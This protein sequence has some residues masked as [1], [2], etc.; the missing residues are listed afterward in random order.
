M[1]PRSPGILAATRALEDG[2]AHNDRGRVLIDLLAL[3]LLVAFALLGAR[4]GALASATLLVA[5]AGGYLGAVLAAIHLGRP[6]ARA[7]GMAPLAG[8]AVAGTAGF[9]PTALGLRARGRGGPASRAPPGRSRRS[10]TRSGR[11][12]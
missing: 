6:V 11:P 9:L 8:T 1:I 10:W 2:P 3:G 12:R 4:R 7:L 5:L